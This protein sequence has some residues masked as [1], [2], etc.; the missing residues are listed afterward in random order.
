MCEAE[1]RLSEIEEE[2]ERLK[3][4]FETEGNEYAIG[5]RC[6]QKEVYKMPDSALKDKVVFLVKCLQFLSQSSKYGIH[7]YVD[8]AH[9]ITEER[10]V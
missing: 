2:Y 9:E 5:S 1:D 6:I 10:I 7:K 4:L 8:L 3:A